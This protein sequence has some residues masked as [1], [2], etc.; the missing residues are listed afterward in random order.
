MNSRGGGYKPSE[1]LICCSGPTM[2]THDQDLYGNADRDVSDCIRCR[3]GIWAEALDKVTPPLPFAPPSPSPLA[4]PAVLDR[5]PTVIALIARRGYFVSYGLIPRPPEIPFQQYSNTTTLRINF[6][7]SRML[8]RSAPSLLPNQG[9]EQQQRLSNVWSY[10]ACR[11]TTVDQSSRAQYYGL[12][13]DPLALGRVAK[14]YSCTP[15]PREES[16]L[17]LLV[18]LVAKQLRIR[19]GPTTHEGF[20]PPTLLCIPWTI[21]RLAG[22]ILLC[23]RKDSNLRFLVITRTASYGFEAVTMTHKGFPFHILPPYIL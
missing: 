8:T 20:L 5:P 12:M 7:Y 11:V 3:R 16:N 21:T 19:G 18:K 22:T 2:K 17:P 23:L 6:R 14:N 9:A 15:C 4:S 13:M 10:R 1:P